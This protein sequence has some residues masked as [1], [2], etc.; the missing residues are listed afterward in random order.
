M[1]VMVWAGLV[2]N[3]SWAAR[4]TTG[5]LPSFKATTA[6]KVG[7]FFSAGMTLGACPGPGT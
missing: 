3:M 1:P 5:R 2:V 4:P 7:R 6:A